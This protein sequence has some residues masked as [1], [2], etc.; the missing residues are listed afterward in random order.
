LCTVYADEEQEQVNKKRAT[1]EGADH[2]QHNATPFPFSPF[3]PSISCPTNNTQNPPPP[4]KQHETIYGHIKE[5]K[6]FEGKE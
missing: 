4:L 5:K 2:T 6:N 1:K 3:L